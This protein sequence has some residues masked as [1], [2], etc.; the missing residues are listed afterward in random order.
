MR[1]NTEHERL[2]FRIAEDGSARP[3]AAAPAF[4]SPPVGRHNPT[5]AIIG[6]SVI[7]VLAGLLSLLLRRRSSTL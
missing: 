1:L 2:V 7:A 4:T 5:I 3:I 6:W